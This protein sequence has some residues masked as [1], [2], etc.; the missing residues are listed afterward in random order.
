MNVGSQVRN[1]AATKLAPMKT[2][3]SRTAARLVRIRTTLSQRSSLRGR[4]GRQLIVDDR[5]VPGRLGLFR[6]A[7]DRLDQDEAQDKRIGRP[8]QAQDEE[9]RPPAECSPSQ[10]ASTAPPAVPR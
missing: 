8:R 10:P 6:L 3:R 5:I 1:V 9:R 7:A 2:H 4:A